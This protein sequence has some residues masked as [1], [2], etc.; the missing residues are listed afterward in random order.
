[1]ISKRFKLISGTICLSPIILGLLW[2][3]KL[4]DMM[5]TN[6]SGAAMLNKTIVILIVPIFFFGMHHL[7]LK[8]SESRLT[9]LIVPLK[10]LAPILSIVVTTAIYY[11]NL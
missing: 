3:N 8:I 4:P 11:L 6:L 9:P 2:Y 10:Y 7:I 5:L 1:M